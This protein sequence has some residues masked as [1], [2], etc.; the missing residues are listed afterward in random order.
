[1]GGLLKSQCQK[2]QIKH[3]E[4]KIKDTDLRWN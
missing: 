4:A 3:T 2:K 1:M